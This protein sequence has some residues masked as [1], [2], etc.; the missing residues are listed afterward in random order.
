MSPETVQIQTQACS[1]GDGKHPASHRLS[2]Q[3]N[4]CLTLRLILFLS[5]H[6][7]HCC[8]SLPGHCCIQVGQVPSSIF[9]TLCHAYLLSPL[10]RTAS[11]L[12]SLKVATLS[13]LP[14]SAPS[15]PMTKMPSQ[16]SE[17]DA[18]GW[19]HSSLTSRWSESV[20]PGE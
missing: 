4:I 11:P 14:G 8:H 20:S 18:S 9:G 13:G 7:S 2:T 17:I 3:S 10:I 16:P 6:P 1:V 12:R 15:S 19:S 5:I